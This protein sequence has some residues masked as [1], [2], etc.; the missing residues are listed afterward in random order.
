MEEHLESRRHCWKCRRD[1]PPETKVCV[2]CGVNLETGELLKPEPTWEEIEEEHA[3]KT[4]GEWLG[5][6]IPG[7]YRPLL[8]LGCVAMALVAL[9]LWG[10]SL[11]LLSQGVAIT[12]VVVGAVGMIAWGQGVVFLLAGRFCILHDGLAD[13]R[14]PQWQLL[15]FLVL[16]P[17]VL[18]GIYLKISLP[19]T[20]TGG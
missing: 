18:F 6:Y 7:L 15:A 19:P 2:G 9:V 12:S 10:L 5:C 11:V 14:G 16:L 8:I 3:P 13:L 4:V 1:Y 17:L 20:V